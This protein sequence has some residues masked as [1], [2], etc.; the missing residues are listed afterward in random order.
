MSADLIDSNLATKAFFSAQSRIWF[1]RYESRTYRQRRNLIK[2]IVQKHVAGLNVEG[3]AIE[4]LDFGC[5]TGV[6]SKDLAEL[7]ASVTGVDNSEAMI[8]AAQLYL[9]SMGSRVRLEWVSNDSGAGG[10][11][12]RVYDVVL[13]VSVLEFVEDMQTVA[14]RLSSCVAPGG[15]L[16]LTVPNRHSWL[17]KIEK[18]V[19]RHPGILRCFSRLKHLAEPECYLSIQKHQLTLEEL[20]HILQRNGMLKEEHRFCVAPRMLGRLERVEKVGMTLVAIFRKQT[21]DIRF[22]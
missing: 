1:A 7:G 12:D 17:R 14:S 19:Y 3:G 15:V 9:R 8:D 11:E 5:G 20:S 10:Y 13:C 6:L 2:E 18:I 16:I 4:V 21:V 22:P